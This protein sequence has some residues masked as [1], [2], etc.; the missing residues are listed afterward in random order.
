MFLNIRKP[1]MNEMEDLPKYEM[2]SSNQFIPDSCNDHGNVVNPRR[3]HVKPL[4]GKLSLDI[5]RKRLAYAPEDI[6]R[7]TFDATTQY[8]MNVESENRMS[9]RRHFKPR[10]QF[11]KEKRINDIFHSDTFFPSVKRIVQKILPTYAHA[12]N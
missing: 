11:M 4:P 7:K 10:F 1:T 8:A 5:W 9:G 2:T 12:K 6:I 3:K